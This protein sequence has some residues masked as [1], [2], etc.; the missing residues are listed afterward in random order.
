MFERLPNFVSSGNIGLLI[1]DSIAA[2]FRS[3][4]TIEEGVQRAKDLR[5]IG[6]QL[7]FLS[8]K[9]NLCVLCVNQVF[10]YNVKFISLAEQIEKT[11][12]YLKPK[13]ILKILKEKKE[14]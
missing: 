13:F 7:H 2:I 6:F 10:Q 9:F 5:S 3:T 11:N 1:I 12:S 8:R 4:Y 14:K